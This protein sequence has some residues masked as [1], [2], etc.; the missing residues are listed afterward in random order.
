[1]LILNTFNSLTFFTPANSGKV[2]WEIYKVANIVGRVLNL[3]YG[4]ETDKGGFCFKHK[5]EDCTK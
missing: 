5:V 4:G 2:V 1:M 3:L